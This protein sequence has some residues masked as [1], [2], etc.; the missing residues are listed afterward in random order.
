M[1]PEGWSRERKQ[2]ASRGGEITPRGGDRR[3]HRHACQPSIG[4]I[5]ADGQRRSACFAASSRRD[6][7]PGT[8]HGNGT[9]CTSVL[10]TFPMPKAGP[11]CSVRTSPDSECQHGVLIDPLTADASQ[12]ARG[13]ALVAIAIHAAPR[14][15]AAPCCHP[16]ALFPVICMGPRSLH[17]SRGD[18]SRQAVCNPPSP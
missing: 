18:E 1:I 4:P 5:P 16:N 3:M 12:A 14:V 6:R 8:V 9:H 13:H 17:G 7:I 10:S 11:P 15:S 2:G